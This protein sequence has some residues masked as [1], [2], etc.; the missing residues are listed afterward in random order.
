MDAILKEKKIERVSILLNSKPA[1]SIFYFLMIT[2]LFS[3]TLRL[4]PKAYA[5]EKLIE[6][7]S[8]EEKKQK[9]KELL[10]LGDELFDQKIYDQ[11]LE[12]YEEV[13]TLDP[14]NRKASAKIDLLKEQMMKE[15]KDEAGV[16]NAVYEEEENERTKKYWAET[17]DYLKEHRYGQA[18]FSLEK[19]LLL[20]P[21]NE[22]A[23]DL[24][25]KLKAKPAG[26][27]G[28]YEKREAL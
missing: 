22:E 2:A 19:I 24:Y 6:D 28:Q 11:A 26:G 10:T 27:A 1:D 18:R 9:V 13:F 20:D 25:E 12:A 7:Y 8:A 5:Q 4:S 21:F 23:K 16:V 15:G 14:K 17:R 3:T